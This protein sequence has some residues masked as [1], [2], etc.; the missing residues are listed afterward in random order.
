MLQQHLR[1]SEQQVGMHR[2]QQ[3][4]HAS[5]VH[6]LPKE[7]QAS[8]CDA[9]DQLADAIVAALAGPNNSSKTSSNSSRSARARAQSCASRSPTN[10][11]THCSSSTTA[12][13]PLSGQVVS[14]QD[15]S[16]TI[17]ALATLHIKPNG[18]WMGAFI[19]ASTA[20]MAAASPQE[21][22]NCL[23]GLQ[24]S[25]TWHPHL[26]G[27]SCVHH[28]NTSTLTCCMWAHGSRHCGRQ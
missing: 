11:S 7:Q 13:R 24:V 17:W 27:I 18:A 16:N 2:R 5:G 19:S 4:Q 25:G 21:L 20:S 6:L 23:W 8:S 1:Q 28:V 15:L 10:S 26:K 12:V 22:V 9:S 3:Q 14:T